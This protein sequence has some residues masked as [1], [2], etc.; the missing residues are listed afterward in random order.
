M[1]SYQH[2][3]HAGN[4][5]DIQKHLW[6]ITVLDY[7]LKK[8]KPF[9]WIDTHSGR[10]LYDLESDEAK[11]VGEFNEGIDAIMPLLNNEE[12]ITASV[13]LQKYAALL[14]DL[15]GENHIKKYPGS[16]YIAAKMLRTT[17][18]LFA[19]DL[20]KG[21]YPHLEA[22]LKNFI[23]TK[24]E[25]TDGYIALKGKIPP[26]LKRGGVL[27]D[28]SYEVKSEYVSCAKNILNAYQKWPQGIYMIWYPILPAQNHLE[29]IDTIKQSDVPDDKIIVDEWHFVGNER[30]MNGTGMIIINPPYTAENDMKSIKNQLKNNLKLL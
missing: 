19:H 4:R 6:L 10:G 11:K 30:G 22:T 26:Q 13:P 8:D 24:L 18:R 2:I 17:D 3:Y 16:A 20:H 5:A 29:M 27:C 14:K 12:T 28:P 23:N 9:Q 25:F 15:N 1:L 21:E 7:L